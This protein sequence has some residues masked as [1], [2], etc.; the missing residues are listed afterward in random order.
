LARAVLNRGW[1]A[2]GALAFIVGASTSAFGGAWTLPQGTGQVIETLYGWTGFGPP[3]GGNPPANQSR[4]DAQTYVQYGLTDSL[5]AFG[6]TA[7]EHYAIGEPTPNT[8]N[9]LDYSG[10]GL[11]QKLWSTGDWIFSGEATVFIPGAHDSK[12]P[13]QEGNTGWAGEARLNAGRN[14]T[15]AS[16][17]GLG[18]LPL[19]GSVPAFLD[20]EV[21]YRLRT[22]GPPDEWHGDLTVGFKF[23]PKIMLMLQDFTTVSMSTNNPTFPAWRQ[24]VA[25]ASVVYALDNKWSLQLGVFST[26]WTVKTNSERG[27]TIAVWRNF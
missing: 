22:E 18:W 16:I 3:W 9:G 10:L 2:S 8:Y 5:T 6:E 4:F 13:A 14:F 26:V 11:R 21:A 27:G 15:L 25:E 19:I 17:P 20:A 12:A 7:F 24:S 23:T 1:V